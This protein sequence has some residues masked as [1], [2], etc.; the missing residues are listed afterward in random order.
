MRKGDWFLPC[1]YNAPLRRGRIRWHGLAH[2]QESSQATGSCNL[3]TWEAREE[4]VREGMGEDHTHIPVTPLPRYQWNRHIDHLKSFPCVPFSVCVVAFLLLMLEREQPGVE[5]PLCPWQ[6]EGP[7][8]SSPASKYWGNCYSSF[9]SLG[10]LHRLLRRQLPPFF[11]HYANYE[12]RG[13]TENR[14]LV[15]IDQLKSK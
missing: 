8:K 2:C 1:F 14:V 10:S 5:M 13:S 15:A 7:G 4:Q 9:K 3:Q 11:S 6:E 12:I